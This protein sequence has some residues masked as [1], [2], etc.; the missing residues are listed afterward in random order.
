MPSQVERARGGIVIA[1]ESGALYIIPKDKL[2]QFKYTDD[3]IEDKIDALEKTGRLFN[4][5]AARQIDE[6]ARDDDLGVSLFGGA[7]P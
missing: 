1:S 3:D 6:Q 5:K 2:D 4:L 7:F